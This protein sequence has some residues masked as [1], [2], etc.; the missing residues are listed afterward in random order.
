MKKCFKCKRSKPRSLFYRHPRM[1][2]GLLGKC[3]SCTK[4]DSLVRYQNQIGKIIEYESKRSKDPRRIAGRK[5]YDRLRRENS[6]G[7]FKAHYTLGNAVR[8][9]RIKR[10]ACSVCGSIIRI[11]GHHQDYRKPLDVVWV[12]R[13]HHLE[14]H[15]KNCWL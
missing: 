7:K 3:K 14:L 4:K 11:E 10:G 1:D 12:C 2:D 13:K 5:K 15:G 6:P 8:D 9:G